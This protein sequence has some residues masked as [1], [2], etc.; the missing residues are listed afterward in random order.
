[1]TE[2]LL[3]KPCSTCGATLHYQPGASSLDCPYCGSQNDIAAAPGDLERFDLTSALA[4]QRESELPPERRLSCP[5]CGA[6]A[7]MAPQVFA[8]SCG[9]CETVLIDQDTSLRRFEPQGL[10]P[11]GVDEGQARERLKRWLGSLW[12]APSS[13]AKLARPKQRLRG[14]YVPYWAFDARSQTDYRGQRGTVH[15]VTRRVQ[16]MRNG[17]SQWTTRSQNVTRWRSVSGQVAREFE[18]FLIQADGGLEALADRRFSSWDTG[19]LEAYNPDYLPGYEARLYG[20]DLVSGWQ[21][22]QIAMEGVIRQDIRH[23]IGG[24]KQRINTLNTR[25][26]DERFTL[27]LLP[28]WF[29]EFAYGGKRYQVVINGLTGEVRGQRP[30]AWWKVALAVLL[31][32][33]LI[34]AALL[35]AAQFEG[36]SLLPPGL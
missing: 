3:H 31:G 14:I 16:V 21:A 18:D 20:M 27:V 4:G 8:Q 13:L 34:A 2:T 9:F 36:V 12:F 1:M 15:R 35:I 28:I 30:V 29:S 19:A 11:F 22:A 26:W 10:L 24:D 6:E 33:G 5:S 23:D 7:I 25:Y 32:L 17:K